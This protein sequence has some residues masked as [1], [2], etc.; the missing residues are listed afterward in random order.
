MR[1]NFYSSLWWG[2]RCYVR[3]C[4]SV[5]VLTTLRFRLIFF[6]PL[7]TS[8]LEPDLYLPLSEAQSVGNFDPPPSGQVAVEVEFL[9]QLQRL[10]PG[11]RLT[12]SLPLWNSNRSN[13]G[14]M[15]Y[16]ALWCTKEQMIL[17]WVYLTFIL[18]QEISESCSWKN[19]ES[20]LSLS[21]PRNHTRSGSRSPTIFR[22]RNY[23]FLILAHP[24]YK[25]WIIQEPNMLELW[26]KLHFEGK[27]G[28][29]IP[30]LKY[31]VPIFV[32]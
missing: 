1:G 14:K 19:R 2:L 7:H 25:I 15:E 17:R 20:K 28:E 3:A 27:K 24:V 21:R 30:C 8:V 32:E 10:V 6:L 31:S 18:R 11:V 26:N 5:T 22:R 9:L 29:Y 23:F 12:P 16:F 13:H 4:A